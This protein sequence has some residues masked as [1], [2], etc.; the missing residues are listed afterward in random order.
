MAEIMFKLFI[1]FEN[2][3]VFAP[4]SISNLEVQFHIQIKGQLQAG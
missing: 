3:S 2:P 4:Y 1:T